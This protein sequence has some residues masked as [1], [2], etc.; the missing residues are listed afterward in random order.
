[1]LSDL[2]VRNL[3]V[4]YLVY[5]L[6]LFSL[7]L[8]I[9]I[10]VRAAERSRFKLV[11]NLWLLGWFGI[12]HGISEFMDMFLVIRG[13]H[14]TLALIDFLA[15]LVSYTLI[16]LFGYRLINLSS[17]NRL[18]LWFPLVLGAAFLALPAYLNSTTVDVWR[19]SAR[20]F[21]GFPAAALSAAAIL[22]Y[23]RFEFKRLLEPQKLRPYFISAAVFFALYGLIAGLVVPR[24][25][26]FPANVINNQSFNALFGFPPQVLRALAAIGIAWSMWHVINVF[27][28]EAAQ[29]RRETESELRRARDDLEQRVE[30]RTAELSRLYEAERNIA[31][32]LQEALLTVPTKIPG[33]AFGH[34]Y[35]SAG[36]EIGKVGGDFYDVFE[37]EPGKI[38]LVIGDVSGK[39]LQAATLTSLIRNT[40]KAYSYEQ[41]SPATVMAMT[42]AVVVKSSAGSMFATVFFGS[43]DMASG[44]LTYCCA[45]HPPPLIKRRSGAVSVLETPSP[46]VGVLAAF[47]Y[48]DRQEILNK[49]DALVLY[50]DGLI[51]ARCGGSLFGESR[52]RVFLE[53]RPPM[54]AG[55]LPQAIFDETARL[56]CRLRDDLAIVALALD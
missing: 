35:R 48:A 24:A 45:G 34:L 32:T 44:A 27:N 11:L 7:G 17:G 38:N 5:G 33:A 18:G 19:I 10:Q 39:G 43:L 30:E 40:I 26:F 47:R 2:L 25:G 8:M 49:G 12:V 42:N 54:P 20:Y 13:D 28:L 51:E 9:F 1:M 14:S 21:V 6:A 23:Y 29:R 55:R 16:F 15:L 56:N 31:D 4:I 37:I 52:L 50:T 3:D 53:G 22:L 46:A 36:T 41:S